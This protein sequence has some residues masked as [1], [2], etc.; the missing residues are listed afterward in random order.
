MDTVWIHIAILAVFHV[1]LSNCMILHY[2]GIPEPLSDIIFGVQI[3]ICVSRTCLKNVM[4]FFSIY[5]ELKS[6]YRQTENDTAN[7]L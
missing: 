7:S 5:W 4:F 3:Q 1:Y 6:I 2:T